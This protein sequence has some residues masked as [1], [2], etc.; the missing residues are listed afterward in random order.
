MNFRLV[1]VGSDDDRDGSPA[2]Q[3]SAAAVIRG[4]SGTTS[5]ELRGTEMVRCERRDNGRRRVTAVANFTARIVGDRIFDDEAEPGREFAVEAELGGQRI[6]FSVSAVEFSRMG[7]VL[8]KLG[9]LAILYPGQQQHARAAIQWLSGAIR[10]ERIFRHTGWRALGRDWVYLQSGGAVGAQGLRCDVQV[11]LPAALA[12]YQVRPPADAAE[13]V[14]AIRAGLRFLCVAPDR[15]SC[16]LL[17]A[18]YRAALGKVDISL[19]LAGPSGSFKTA[20]ASLCQQHFGAAMDAKAL[21]AHFDST[22]NALEALAFTAKDAL[23]VVDD[24]VP[25]GGTGDG[26]LQSTSERLFRGAGNHQ[27]RSRMS[28]SGRLRTPQTPRALVLATGEE[29]PRGQSLR[30]RMLIV[31]LRPAEVDRALLTECQ[32][33]ARQGQL[34]VAMAAFLS[35]IAGQYEQLQ[36]RLQTRVRELRNRVL[37]FVSHARLPAALAELQSGW[38]IWLQFAL[39][40]GGIGGGEQ[41]ELAH[42]MSRALGELAARQAPYQVA[43]DPALR[44]VALLQ[45]A[46]AS[47]QAHVAD[48]LGGV[49]KAASLWGWKR[50]PTGRKWIACGACIGWIAGS[51]LYLDSSASYQAAQQAAGLDRFVASEQTLRRRLHGHG[52]LVSIDTGRQTL[53]VRKTLGGCPRHVLHLKASAL[54]GTITETGANLTL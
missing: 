31:E 35:W 26:E 6:T 22:A 43:N 46:L 5:Y 39:E 33:A 19:F 24:F 50:K 25:T 28:G 8:S 27:G 42:R 9:P 20:L 15:I 48:R 11:Q 18:V 47:G 37:P 2:A 16:P 21:P 29:V 12:H 44:F 38:E 32:S 23:L 4:Q 36:R 13:G 10:Q 1:W 41:V 40:A 30:A 54:V 49:P 53:L 52:L 7:W 14:S 51:D 34:A 45:S 3:Q 17:A